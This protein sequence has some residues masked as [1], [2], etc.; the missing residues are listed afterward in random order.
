MLK[1]F[2]SMLLLIA[3]FFIFIDPVWCESI[4]GQATLHITLY[5][6]PKPVTADTVPGTYPEY[7]VDK[8]EDTIFITAD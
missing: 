6:P 3:A 8:T 2:V 7:T 1:R 4:I 5:V